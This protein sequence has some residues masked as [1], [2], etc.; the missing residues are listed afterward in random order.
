M[1]HARDAVWEDAAASWAKA[2]IRV[3]HRVARPE[4]IAAFA[5]TLASSDFPYMTGAQMV[6]D[7][8]KTTYA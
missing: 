5:L 6:I 3:A 7:G 4:E 1:M 8:G 2:N